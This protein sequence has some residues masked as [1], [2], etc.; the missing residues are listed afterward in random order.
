MPRRLLP[1]LVLL[2]VV[3]TAASRSADDLAAEGTTR[4]LQSALLRDAEAD[5]RAYP[6]GA[7]RLPTGARLDV[8]AGGGEFI[9]DI[10]VTPTSLVPLV[11]LQG[12]SGLLEPSDG[13]GPVNA[14]MT[15]SYDGYCR[16]CTSGFEGAMANDPILVNYAG[17]VV[18]GMVPEL[19]RR[20]HPAQARA[21]HDEV[22][23]SVAAVLGYWRDPHEACDDALGQGQA[24]VV[25]CFLY[26][27]A[28]EE[29]GEPRARSTAALW[30]AWALRGA[31][32]LG[33]DV[34]AAASALRDDFSQLDA[35]DAGEAVRVLEPL[36]RGG[37]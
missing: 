31:A 17:Q 26:R 36:L 18:T 28:H 30:S 12:A 34:R 2:P 1:A 27:R 23:E 21:L 4:S 33:L 29:S 6:V 24:M 13:E 22:A 7:T 15:W 9:E 20:L 35:R 37:G 19:A 14:A 11:L 10:A 5:A 3:A 32:S 25:R 8:H 16:G